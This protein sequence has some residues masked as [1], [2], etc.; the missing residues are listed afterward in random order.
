VVIAVQ[1]QGRQ[2]ARKIGDIVLR[3][4]D[5]LL[6]E[7]GPRFAERYRNSSDFH[8]VNALEGAAAWAC[9]KRL[10]A[11]GWVGAEERVVLFNTGS[12]LKYL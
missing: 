7:T 4:G 12:G 10:A 3:P 1:R 2:L 8:V 9:L 6:L 5:T 11:Q